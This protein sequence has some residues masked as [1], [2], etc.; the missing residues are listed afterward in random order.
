MLRLTA[1]ILLMSCS[2]AET[3]L[4][5]PVENAPDQPTVGVFLLRDVAIVN[6]ETGRITVGQS[7][8]LRGGRIE[9]VGPDGGIPAPAE[10]PQHVGLLHAARAYRADRQP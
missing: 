1:L 8:L 5:P 10:A 2:S 6:V 7:V 3:V 9:A 4:A